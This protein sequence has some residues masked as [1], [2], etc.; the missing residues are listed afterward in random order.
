MAAHEFLLRPRRSARDLDDPFSELRLSCRRR[1]LR[2]ADRLSRDGAL[3]RA[4]ANAEASKGDATPLHSVGHCLGVP[5]RSEVEGVELVHLP[6]QLLASFRE[7]LR[8]PQ[9][10]LLPSLLLVSPLRS[11]EPP[12][13]V[14]RLCAL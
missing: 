4:T 11:H 2:L 8:L 10:R 7:M 6:S 3:R 5:D 12:H 1:A 9:N 14:L 13:H